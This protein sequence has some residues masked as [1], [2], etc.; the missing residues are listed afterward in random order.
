MS[1]QLQPSLFNLSSPPVKNVPPPPPKE[2]TEKLFALALRE[3]GPMAGK[4]IFISQ[5]SACG[6][7]YL[8][9]TYHLLRVC[10]SFKDSGRDEAPSPESRP[11][12]PET[13]TPSIAPVAPVKT[14]EIKAS[15]LPLIDTPEKDPPENMPGVYRKDSNERPNKHHAGLTEASKEVAQGEG[16]ETQLATQGEEE[17]SGVVD[18]HRA[19][20]EGTGKPYEVGKDHQVKA[21]HWWLWVRAAPPREVIGLDGKTYQITRKIQEPFTPSLTARRRSIPSIACGLYSAVW[22]AALSFISWQEAAPQYLKICKLFHEID[23]GKI[24][25]HIKLLVFCDM[26]NER[27]R[28]VARGWWSVVLADGRLPQWRLVAAKQLRLLGYELADKEPDG[29][30]ESAGAAAAWF[31]EGEGVKGR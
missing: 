31:L 19:T 4:P 20:G 18:A 10:V 14:P 24:E 27:V 23:K 21:P 17:R 28:H 13:I 8:S 12:D 25:T 5:C 22:V 1:K 30:F 11:L 2:Q 7:P 9:I 3:S 6:K 29:S 26:D 15:P 16:R